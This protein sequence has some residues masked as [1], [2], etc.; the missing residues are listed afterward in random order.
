MEAMSI[1]VG[2]V[3]GGLAAL[4]AAVDGVDKT[5]K[6]CS[7]FFRYIRRK[8]RAYGKSRS[9]KPAKG[10]KLRP[11]TSMQ[12]RGSKK[13]GLGCLLTS[14]GLEGQVRMG[15]EV[16]TKETFLPLNPRQFG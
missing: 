13:G 7:K 1:T 14:Q 5:V 16:S 8:A 11:R 15:T 12:R 9:R 6:G 4:G 2:L 10:K 3:L